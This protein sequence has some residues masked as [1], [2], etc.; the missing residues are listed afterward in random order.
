MNTTNMQTASAA[1]TAP[2]TKPRFD[3]VDTDKGLSIV[4]VVAR[5][6]A[7]G[8]AL[9]LGKAPLIFGLISTLA[10]PY[11]MPL[12][13][14]VAGLFAAD[15]MRRPLREFL[16]KKLLHFAYF[17]FLWSAIQIGMKMALPG[18]LH[19]VGVKDLLLT[20][21]EPFGV[22]WFI[23][24]LPLFFV[25]MRLMRDVP[26]ILVVAVA[27]VFYFAR[28]DTGWTVPDESAL[29]FIFFVIGVYCAPHVFQIA[30]WARAHVLQATLVGVIVLSAIGVIT[31]SPLID[32]RGI[33]FLA[34][35]AGCIGCVMLVSA[36]AAKGLT[37]WL[38]YIGSRSLYVFVAFFLPMAA[39]RMVMIK[40][41]VTNGDLVTFVAVALG[42]ILPLVAARLLE[43]TRLGFL[44][45]RPAF[46]RLPAKGKNEDKTKDKANTPAAMPAYQS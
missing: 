38:T 32:L 24:A 35:V 14:V 18:G 20:P 7:A 30:D 6:T 44:F 28:I 3:W 15:Y 26:K 21:I 43:G 39:A 4:L 8:V 29:R 37:G 13:F 34:G 11:R 1:P 31:L 5:H 19:D 36:A 46:L 16:D 12:F 22:L 10:S 41:G 23:Y 9:S 42:V 17:Y 40:A 25:A 27:L 33:E 45:T 2:T